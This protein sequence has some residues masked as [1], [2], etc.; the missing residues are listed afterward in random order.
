VVVEIEVEAVVL[1]DL[2]FEFGM[3]EMQVV[4]EEIQKV[5]HLQEV[6]VVPSKLPLLSGN[7]LQD[8]RYV[9]HDAIEQREACGRLQSCG[10]DIHT[11]EQLVLAVDGIADLNVAMA[12]GPE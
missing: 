3:V 1:E 5:S 10:A 2:R 8:L 7:Q 12:I 6:D 9:V 4:Q 11:G